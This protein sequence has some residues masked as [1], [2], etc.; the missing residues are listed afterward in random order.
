MKMFMWSSNAFNTNSKLMGYAPG[1]LA[2]IKEIGRNRFR[3][4]LT[5]V[6]Q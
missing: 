4:D 1:Y 2:V 3:W 6:N 5:H